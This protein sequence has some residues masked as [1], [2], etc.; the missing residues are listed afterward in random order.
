MMFSRITLAS[1]MVIAVVA[2]SPVS[3]LTFKKG[4]VLGADGEVYHG[5]SPEQ[6]QALI[7]KA[8]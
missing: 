2:V 8:K 1:L 4:E 3:A 6:K 5:A 7:E